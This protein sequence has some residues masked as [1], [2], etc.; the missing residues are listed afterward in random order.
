M[1]KAPMFGLILATVL[2]AGALAF[3]LL[4]SLILKS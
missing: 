4:A 3:D 1:F 2:V